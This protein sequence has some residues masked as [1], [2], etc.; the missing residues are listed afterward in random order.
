MGI[1]Q[2]HELEAYWETHWLFDTPGFAKVMQRNRFELI[3]SFLHFND[4]SQHVPRGEE[5]HDRLFK[6]RPVID[7]VIPMF[8]D[9]FVPQKELSLDEMTIAFKER[10]TLKQYNPKKPDKW[11]Y[12]EL[13]LSEAKT[14]YVLNWSLYA[15]KDDERNPEESATY[16]IVKNLCVNHLDKGNIIFMDSYYT[17]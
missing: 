15:G 12:K 14:G 1:V 9:L 5:G 11:G 8:K 17:S 6:V 2:K 10:S 4:N 3:L 16:T 7:M 13:A